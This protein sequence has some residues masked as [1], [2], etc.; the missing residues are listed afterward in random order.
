M[1][2]HKSLGETSRRQNRRASL[3]KN[4]PLIL[5]SSLIHSNPNSINKKNGG[6]CNIPTLIDVKV[7]K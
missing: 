7:S 4:N 1:I 5:K 3:L 6:N 2:R